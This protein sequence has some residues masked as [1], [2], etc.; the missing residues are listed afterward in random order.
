VRPVIRRPASRVLVG[1]A[2]LGLGLVA[3]TFLNPLDAYGPGQSARADG[4][5]DA[6]VVPGDGS[7]PLARW[8]TRPAADGPSIGDVV[9]AVETIDL[10]T[11]T[12]S[13]TIGYDLDGVCTCPG[14]ASC[15]GPANA[16]P[17]CDLDGGIDVG[18]SQALRDLLQLSNQTLAIGDE[19]KGGKRGVLL[20]LRDYN[21]RPDDPRVEVDTFLSGGTEGTQ[22]GNPTPPTRDGNDVWTVDPSTLFTDKVPPYAPIVADTQGYVSGGV[23]VATLDLP[24]HLAGIAL[25]LRQAVVTGHLDHAASDPPLVYHL[26]GG[27]IA[28]REPIAKLLTSLDLSHDPFGNG[29]AGL[30]GDSGTYHL[31]KG[32]LCGAVDLM[33]DP[34][35]DNQN[36]P[37]D[38]VG[39]AFA[40][41]AG[42]AQLGS[43]FAPPARA[44]LCGDAWTDDCTTP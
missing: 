21:G 12:T 32:R 1:A 4:G 36:D 11:E 7:C 40:F 39:L 33:T 26:S 44:H 35:R 15:N 43:A 9:L 22:T 6:G 18:G 16:K 27:Q 38:A 20:R 17:A 31:V 19:I 13:A 5:N 28:G 42:P 37:C 30:C 10:G 2:A 29:T 25:D 3:C 41:T 34:K 23:L 24:L 8:P 14:P